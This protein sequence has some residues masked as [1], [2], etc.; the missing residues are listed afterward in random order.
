MH[1]VVSEAERDAVM[2]KPTS[3]AVT[4]ALVVTALGLMAAILIQGLNGDRDAQTGAAERVAAPPGRRRV[5]A[6][7]EAEIRKA[8]LSLREAMY[9][10]KLPEKK[11]RCVLCPSRCVLKEGQRG[12]CRV[13]A[14]IDGIL[15]TLVYGRLVA[16]HNDPIEKKPLNHFMPGTRAFSIAT[17]GCNLGCVFCQNWQISQAYPEKAQFMRATPESVVAMAKRQNCQS[18]AYTYT[19]PT[20]FY[21]FML[22]CAKLARKQGLKNVWITCGYINPEPLKELCQVMDAANIDLKGYSEE[23]YNEYCRASLKPVLETLKQARAAGLWI[24]VTNLVIPGANDRPEMI[25]AMCR[26]HMKH[27]GADVPLHFSRFFPRYRLLDRS[28]TPPATLRTAAEIAQAE[29]IHHV[30]L[31]NIATDI[32]RDTVC[33]ACGQVC[34]ARQGYFIRRNDLREGKC[35]KCGTVIKGVW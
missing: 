14:N 24:E 10:E 22:D 28:P 8:G 7:S 17:A 25:R 6:L 21:E 9:Y 3:N 20:I 33:P 26:W 32:G 5:P 34:I 13:R 11:V 35:P 19:E 30:Y 16:V 12:A 27:M 29:G 31:G 18:I 2:W 23:F 4:T 1:G 15:R